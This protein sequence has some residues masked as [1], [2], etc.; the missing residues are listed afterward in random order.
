MK[1]VHRECALALVVVLGVLTAS[2]TMCQYDCLSS[3]RAA[4]SPHSRLTSDEQAACHTPGTV[5]QATHA[6]GSGESC[7][8]DA[9]VPALVATHKDRSTTRGTMSPLV[10]MAA[11]VAPVAQVHVL[12]VYPH[13][14]VSEPVRSSRVL[15][16]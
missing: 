15:R 1:Q 10:R 13:A 11:L 9:G 16:I 3:E 12:R 6:L 4:R 8:H 2:A 14:P 7:A 5:G